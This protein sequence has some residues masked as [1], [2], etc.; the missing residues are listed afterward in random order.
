MRGDDGTGWSLAWKINFWA[1]LHEGNRAFELLKKLLRPVKG[2]TVVNMSNGGGTY[3]NLF[4]AHPPFQI[5]GNFGGTAGIAEMLVQSQDGYI[6]LIPA[7]PD[8]WQSGSFSGLCVRGGAEISVAWEN[9]KVTKMNIKATNNGVFKI[10][11]P[12]N[13]LYA[14][15]EGPGKLKTIVQSAEQYISLQLR[16]GDIAEIKFK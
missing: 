11:I 15:V 10:K 4:C 5:D 8:N 13:I 7:L 14:D 3:N 12:S 2:G 9:M 1:R 6:D 16:N